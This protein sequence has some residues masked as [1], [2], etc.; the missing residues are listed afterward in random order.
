MPTNCAL[1]ISFG[2]MTLWSD[3][4]RRADVVERDRVVGRDRSV[5]PQRAVTGAPRRVSVP[6]LRE[7]SEMYIGIGTLVA[8][9]II[10]L[11]IVLIF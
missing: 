8:I 2:L 7:G 9:L 4:R 6:R 5:Q 3:R 11:L 1:V 10:V